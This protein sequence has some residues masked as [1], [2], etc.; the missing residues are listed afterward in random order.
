MYHKSVRETCSA[1][2]C[3]FKCSA[4][5]SAEYWVNLYKSYLRTVLFLT[6]LKIRLPINLRF[7]WKQLW[8]F[9]R[10]P[11]TRELHNVSF[12][13]IILWHSRAGYKNKSWTW[14]SLQYYDKAESNNDIPCR[15]PSN[16]QI[17]SWKRRN[18]SGHKTNIN[19]CFFPRK[20]Q[21][22]YHLPR[23]KTGL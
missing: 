5:Y 3:A 22:V 1:G 21:V 8:V 23:C 11:P 20:S 16:R 7:L 15:W 4:K 18:R 10:S 13:R 12:G 14:L 6:V 17:Q 2:K 9:Y 19:K